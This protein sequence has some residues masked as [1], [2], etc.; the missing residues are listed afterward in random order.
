[1]AIPSTIKD[2]E[3]RWRKSDFQIDFRLM[4]APILEISPESMYFIALTSLSIRT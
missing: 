2:I 4:H 3:F 1:M